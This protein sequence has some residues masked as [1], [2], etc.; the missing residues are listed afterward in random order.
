MAGT[1]YELYFTPSQTV[2]PV[3][4][5]AGTAYRNAFS[6][7]TMSSV[8]PAGHGAGA[9]ARVGTGASAP[10]RADTTYAGSAL[11]GPMSMDCDERCKYL[12]SVEADYCSKVCTAIRY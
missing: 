8:R 12:E 1:F 7:S 9:N 6:Y 10:A 2:N 5:L 11:T 3:P 4:P